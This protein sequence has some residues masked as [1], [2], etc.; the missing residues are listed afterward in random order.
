MNL[1]AIS[2]SLEELR[3]GLVASGFDLELEEGDVEELTVTVRPG[4]DACTE[5]LVPK[6]MFRRI[7]LDSIGQT[8]ASP[9]AVVVQYPSDI[10]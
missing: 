7:I 2:A 5:C 9:P 4:P 3:Q 1:A 8:E 10:S 6:S